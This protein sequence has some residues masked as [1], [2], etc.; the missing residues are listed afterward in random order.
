MNQMRED[1]NLS[2]LRW[3]SGILALFFLILAIAG[4]WFYRQQQSQ[5]RQ[6]TEQ[7]LSAIAQ[8][9]VNEISQWRSER[10]AY[11][12]ALSESPFFLDLVKE[13]MASRRQKDE[14]KLLDRFRSIKA[15][16]SFE[17]VLLTDAEGGIVLSLSARTGR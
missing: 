9:K 3:L 17:D 7:F 4:A 1:A 10:L 13:W 8:L 14:Q 11:P 6:R 15:H 12:A 2:S 5:M 16:Y